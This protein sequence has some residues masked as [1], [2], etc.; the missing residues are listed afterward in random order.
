MEWANNVMVELL[1]SCV[2]GEGPNLSHIRMWGM[3]CSCPNTK[4][5][6]ILVAHFAID[7]R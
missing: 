6:K 1:Y 5:R 2:Q 3:L 7:G 4:S